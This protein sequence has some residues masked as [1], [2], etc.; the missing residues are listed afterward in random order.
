[1]ANLT[2]S[3]K[4]RVPHLRIFAVKVA[5]FVLEPFVRNERTGAKICDAMLAFVHRGSRLYLNGE[6]IS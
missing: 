5:V 1:M 2:L 6:R 4:H 3:V